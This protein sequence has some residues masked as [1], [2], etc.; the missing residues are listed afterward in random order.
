VPTRLRHLFALLAA[1]A[2]IATAA[3][4]SGDDAPSPER[5]DADVALGDFERFRRSSAGGLCPD[6]TDCAGFIELAADRVLLVDRIGELPVVVH[7]AE[8]T[9]GELAGAIAILTDRDL[10]ALLDLGEPPCEPPTDVFEQMLLVAGGREHSNSTTFC[11]D[12]PLVAARAVLVELA[13]AYV[14]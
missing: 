8:V 6:D 7:E 10:V 12:A 4:C 5:A 11:D 14:P 2:F 13:D 1:A 9:A 3:G